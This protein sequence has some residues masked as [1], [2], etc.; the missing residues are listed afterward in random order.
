MITSNVISETELNVASSID[1]FASNLSE[2]IGC[3]KSLDV[4]FADRAKSLEHSSASLNFESK[5]KFLNENMQIFEKYKELITLM[6][7]RDDLLKSLE[8]NILSSAND[9]LV[10]EFRN[11]DNEF[12]QA[13]QKLGV[14]PLSSPSD[15]EQK[16]LIEKRNAALKGLI[17]ISPQV[18]RFANEL[19]FVYNFEATRKEYRSLET[20]SPIDLKIPPVSKAFQPL[21]W[22]EVLLKLEVKQNDFKECLSCFGNAVFAEVNFTDHFNQLTNILD[23]LIALTNSKLGFIQTTTTQMKSKILQKSDFERKIEELRNNLMKQS[24]ENQILYWQDLQ[25]K[26]EKCQVIEDQVNELNKKKKSLTKEKLDM[27]RE[28]LDEENQ[29][30]KNQLEEAILQKDVELHELI[31]ESNKLDR[32]MKN[33]SIQEESENELEIR[34]NFPELYN[35]VM[36]IWEGKYVS[37]KGESLAT[38]M[39]MKANLLSLQT[40]DSYDFDH[41]EPRMIEVLPQNHSQVCGAILIQLPKDAPGRLK[42][43]RKVP[44]KDDSLLRSLLLASKLNHPFMLNIELGFVHSSEVFLQYPFLYGGDLTKWTTEKRRPFLRVLDVFSKIASALTALHEKSIFHRDIKPENIAM[45]SKEND[46][47]PKLIDFEF[48]KEKRP[49]I[50][51]TIRPTGTSIFMAPELRNPFTFDAKNVDL[52]ACDVFAFAVTIIVVLFFK[53]NVNALPRNDMWLNEEETLNIVRNQPNLD[54]KLVEILNLSLSRDSKRRPTIKKVNEVLSERYCSLN[55]HCEGICHFDEGIAC[56]AGRHFICKKDFNDLVSH[57]ISKSGSDPKVLCPVPN[58][59]GNDPFSLR[60]LQDGLSHETFEKYFHSYR[61]FVEAQ[62]AMKANQL[63]QKEIESMEK[64]IQLEGELCL[65]R[66][67]IEDIASSKCPHCKNAWIDFDGC[68]ALTCHISTCKANFCGFCETEHSSEEIHRHVSS[69][70]FNPKLGAVFTSKEEFKEAKKIFRQTRIREYSST[71]EQSKWEE[72]K[73]DPTVRSIL[74]DLG[75]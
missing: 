41:L 40:P 49:V 10:I 30:K 43:F 3:L 61:A 46:A 53:S 68:S 37:S 2:T 6:V 31:S 9:S 5:F 42:V 69:C 16:R 14:E 32:L 67:R 20:R 52:A 56:P 39:L 36:F 21:T 54:K 29:K 23:H 35:H 24:S 48:S 74:R 57:K 51:S 22:D 11:R 12:K 59:D 50:S 64:R 75:M 62:E 66:K 26:L 13:L 28:L 58:C 18:F 60:T 63:L 72:A 47:I 25:N 45:T 71:L 1:K 19:S 73:R 33:L 7:S 55:I 65:I 27:Q 17:E 38:R 15:D 70:Q 44:E 34:C 4:L 8:S